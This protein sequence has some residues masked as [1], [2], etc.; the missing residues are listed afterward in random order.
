MYNQTAKRRFAVRVTKLKNLYSENQILAGYFYAQKSVDIIA[1]MHFHYC[2]FRVLL[3][4]SIL[5]D[6]LL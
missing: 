3:F 5:A 4:F 6:Y 2:K 1:R